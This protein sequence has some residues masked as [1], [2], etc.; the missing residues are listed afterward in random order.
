MKVRGVEVGGFGPYGGGSRAE[1]EGVREQIVQQL[2]GVGSYCVVR[3]S[4]AY[5]KR[6]VRSVR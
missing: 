3:E 6:M 2:S 5:E 1:K 4:Y